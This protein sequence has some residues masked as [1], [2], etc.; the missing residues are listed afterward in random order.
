[1]D[2]V[3]ADGVG[4]ITVINGVARLSLVTL[5]TA[6]GARESGESKPIAVKTHRL[7]MPVAGLA[8]L[9]QQAQG[10][11]ARMEQVAMSAAAVPTPATRLASSP[12]NSTPATPAPAN[13]APPRS[14]N[15]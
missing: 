4:E 11:L 9:V 3:F 7:V 12:A 1:M 8:N 2:D 5:E 6:P 10:L 13:G 14:P 15:F